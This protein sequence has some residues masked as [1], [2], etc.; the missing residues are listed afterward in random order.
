MD[1][2][3]R[4]PIFDRSSCNGDASFR[5][6]LSYRLGLL[7]CVIFDPLSLVER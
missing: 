7:C 3:S 4:Q 1:H 5:W 2:K 6:Y